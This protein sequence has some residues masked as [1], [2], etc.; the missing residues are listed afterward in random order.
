MDSEDKRIIFVVVS[1]WLT[2]L[3]CSVGGLFNGV[4]PPF[5]ILLA[6]GVL[7]GIASFFVWLSGK[8]FKD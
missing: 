6:L 5:F 8:I 1:V 7:G 3:L 2:L 4:E